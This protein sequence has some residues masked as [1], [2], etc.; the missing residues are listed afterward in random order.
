MVNEPE[1]LF[2]KGIK[3]LSENINNNKKLLQKLENE[4][5]NYNHILDKP[6][7]VKTNTM[8]LYFNILIGLL[9]G[10]FFSCIIIFFKSSLKNK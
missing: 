7:I 9:L 3:V 5:F 8:P 2:Y 4:E 6:I 10:F 1:A